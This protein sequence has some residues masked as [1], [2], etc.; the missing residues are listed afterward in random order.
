MTGRAQLVHC[1]AVAPGRG[2]AGEEDVPCGRPLQRVI[3]GVVLF[4]AAWA[5]MRATEQP[6]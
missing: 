2:A 6:A 5:L 3:P 1:G 4:L